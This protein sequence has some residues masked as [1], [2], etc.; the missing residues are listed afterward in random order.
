MNLRE[1]LGAIALGEF[2][3]DLSVIA[4]AVR[5]RQ[6][7]ASRITLQSLK[8]GDRVRLTDSIS[9]KGLSGATG[10][11]ESV[12]QSRASVVIDKEFSS[13]AGRF[14]SSIRLGMPL[15]IPATLIAEVID[16]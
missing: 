10:T 2:D 4:G 5:D 14:S 7:V 1:L 15:T 6:K 12:R 8:K 11:V 9:P 13:V 16:A 3:G